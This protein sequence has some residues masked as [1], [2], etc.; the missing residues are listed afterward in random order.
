M[1][2]CSYLV[3]GQVCK[4]SD[5]SKSSKIL[6]VYYNVIR[7]LP[8]NDAFL[9]GLSHFQAGWVN[10]S[11]LGQLTRF[12]SFQDIV[13]SAKYTDNNHGMFVAG[14]VTKRKGFSSVLTLSKK[15]TNQHRTLHIYPQRAGFMT[16]PIIIKG[17]YKSRSV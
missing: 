12:K 2:K 7:K 8:L 14:V 5:V 10:I 9:T 15:K 3:F 4:V 1:T 6:R 16:K 13:N 11:K 17:W